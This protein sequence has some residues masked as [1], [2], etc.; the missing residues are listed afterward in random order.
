MNWHPHSDSGIIGVAAALLVIALV[1]TGPVPGWTAANTVENRAGFDGRLVRGTAPVAGGVV[2]A[3]R[4]I[5]FS[6]E[7]AAVSMPS[8][9]DGKYN[10]DLMPGT[11]YLVA[12]AG[13]MWTW[14]GQNPMSVAEGERSWVGFSLAIWTNPVVRSTGEESLE[15]RIQ[16]KVL[17]DGEPIEDVTVSLYFDEVDGFRGMGFIQSPPTGPDGIFRMDMV[18][19]GRY[20]LIARKRG[21]GKV[22]GPMMKGDLISWYR[23]N[24]IRVEDGKEL[25][26][27]LP[28]VEKRLEREIHGTRAKEE[29]PG[30]EGVITD[31][32]GRPV[33]GVHVFA[34]V[35]PEMGHHKP[36]ALSSLTD[37]QG[38]Y[39][40]SLPTAGKYYVG[41]RQGYGDNPTPGE[42]FGHYEG[43]ADH[44]L[45]VESERFLQEIGITVKRVL[46]P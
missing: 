34:Y 18:P 41:A 21:S 26:I 6:G 10:L 27:V 17:K 5:D 32:E 30:F 25:D 31:R 33:Q 37:E 24:P 42:M 13:D 16:G 45:V 28:M 12:S 9:S 22:V 43:T 15:G 19:E 29:R 11:Y 7:P 8:G 35:E 46:V 40:I 3:Y 1:F 38:R 20:F 2:S 39:R 23:F 44:S 36:A 4:T 14:C